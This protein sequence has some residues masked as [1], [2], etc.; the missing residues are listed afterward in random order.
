MR[1]IRAYTDHVGF[2]SNTL[3]SSSLFICFGMTTN[4]RNIFS[5]SSGSRTLPSR[6]ELDIMAYA[7]KE[8][9]DKSMLTYARYRVQFTFNG[10]M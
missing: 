10:R 8:N 4:K 9:V 5:C 6:R 2:T 1:F 3:R 7:S